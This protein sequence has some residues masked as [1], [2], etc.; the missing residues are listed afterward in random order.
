MTGSPINQFLGSPLLEDM[1]LLALAAEFVGTFA[2]LTAILFTGNWLAIGMTLAGIILIIGET[3]G[4]HVNPAVSFA[5]FLKGAISLTELVSYS[6]AQCAG[7][8]SALAVF[9][10]IA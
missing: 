10:A 3:S 9:K 5:M 4:G 6:V 1:K 8:A 2:L 7:A